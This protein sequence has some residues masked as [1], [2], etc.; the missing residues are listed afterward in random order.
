MRM[1]QLVLDVFPFP[2][3]IFKAVSDIIPL[4]I[5]TTPSISEGFT[6]LL[7]EISF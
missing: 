1:T 7:F 3:L 4:R 6:Y 2:R 5:D